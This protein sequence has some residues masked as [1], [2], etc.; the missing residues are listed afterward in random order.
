MGE[1]ITSYQAN[2]SSRNKPIGS[3]SIQDCKKSEGNGQEEEQEEQ[4]EKVGINSTVK[5]FGDRSV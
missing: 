5:R 4:K 3:G 2:G 1:F